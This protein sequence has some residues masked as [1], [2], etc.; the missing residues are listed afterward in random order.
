M[1]K[2]RILIRNK[3]QIVRFSSKNF[4]GDNDDLMWSYKEGEG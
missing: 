2:N 1:I 4:D 3:I